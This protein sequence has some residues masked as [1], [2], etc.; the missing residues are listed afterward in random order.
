[1]VAKRP[2]RRKKTGVATVTTSDN[3]CE[4]VECAAADE[5]D[6]GNF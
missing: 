5:D 3:D 2:Q 6:D 1:M 4:D